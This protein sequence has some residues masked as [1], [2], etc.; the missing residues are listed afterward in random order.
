MNVSFAGC[1]FLGIYHVGVASALREYA[2]HLCVGKTAG[3]SAGALAAAGLICDIPFGESTTYVLHIAVKA[4][5]RALGPFHP[6]FDINSIIHDGLCRMLPDNAHQLCSGRLHVSLTRVSDGKNVLISQFD[7]RDDLLQALKCSCFIPFYSGLLPP[8]LAGVAYMD[9]GFSDNLP[10]L[11]ER[12]VTV[13]PFAGDNDICPMDDH[14]SLLQI[15]LCNTSISLTPGNLYRFSRILFPP[16][17]EILSRM[18]QQGFDDAVRFLQKQNMISC[19]RCLAVESSFVVGDSDTATDSG[20]ESEPG[21]HPYD[22]CSE[23]KVRQQSALTEGLPDTIVNAIQHASDQLDKGII[24]WLFRHRPMKLISFITI[25]YVLPIDITIVIFCKL[26]QLLPKLQKE[27]QNSFYKLLSVAKSLAIKL[28]DRKSLHSA[29]FS[30]QLALTEFN[31]SPDEPAPPKSRSRTPVHSARTSTLKEPV[32]VCQRSRSLENLTVSTPDA[33]VSS[34]RP[35]TQRKSYAGTSLQRLQSD[36]ER[37]ISTMN[38]GFTMNLSQVS[39]QRRS[40][41]RRP[42]TIDSLH[43]LGEECLADNIDAIKLTNQALHWERECLEQAEPQNVDNFEHILEVTE[44]QA[45][46][47]AFYY[48][49]NDRTRVTEI[50]DVTSAGSSEADDSLLDLSGAPSSSAGTDDVFALREGVPPRK[51][52]RRKTSFVPKSVAMI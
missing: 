35:P 16:H 52:P 25:P 21:V 12:T 8:K 9:G 30:C 32:C 50:F 28:Q 37:V 11:D 19:T 46:L 36:Y 13:S 18:C 22:G 6:G 49:D 42:S 34:H 20:T 3:A 40:R 45:A 7:T 27:M 1:G 15:N 26:W 17:P 10:N 38:F 43:K 48:T 24:N 31:Y 39:Q 33:S 29:K 41:S 47:M 4:R 23:C 14:F 44:S 2:P 5:E 51:A